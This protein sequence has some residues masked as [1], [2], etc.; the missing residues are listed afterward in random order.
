MYVCRRTAGWTDGWIDRCI[1]VSTD[2]SVDRRMHAR[3]NAWL[4]GGRMTDECIDVWTHC[5][6]SGLI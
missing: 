6:L 3:T 5:Y 2:E 4:E 1:D